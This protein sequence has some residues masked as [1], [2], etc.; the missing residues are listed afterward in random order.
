MEELKRCPF[1]GSKVSLTYH[2]R[3]NTFNFWHMDINSCATV[4]PIQ[5]DGD[6]VKSFKEATE[7]WNRRITDGRNT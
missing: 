2:S 5:F 4:E 6:M 3:D 7:A 1:C